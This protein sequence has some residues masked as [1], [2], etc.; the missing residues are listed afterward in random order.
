MQHIQYSTNYILL[1]NL[2]HGIRGGSRDLAK[3]RKLPK[4][5]A[6]VRHM[7]NNNPNTN[8]IG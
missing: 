8:N 2:T 6:L 4:E 7:E 5:Q 3:G 1:Q